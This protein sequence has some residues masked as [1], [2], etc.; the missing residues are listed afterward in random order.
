MEIYNTIVVS[1]AMTAIK[2]VLQENVKQPWETV[3]RSRIHPRLTSKS[4]AIRVYK[5]SSK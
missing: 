3:V 1:M 2:L 5:H 4:P